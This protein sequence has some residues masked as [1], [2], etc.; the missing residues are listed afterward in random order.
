MRDSKISDPPTNEEGEILYQYDCTDCENNEE[1]TQKKITRTCSDCGG[2]L[3]HVGPVLD[4]CDKCD[5]KLLYKG[6]SGL[7]SD[8]LCDTCYDRM[9]SMM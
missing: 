6:N 3:I 8:T 5:A 1:Y 2:K 9:E 4:I 7:G